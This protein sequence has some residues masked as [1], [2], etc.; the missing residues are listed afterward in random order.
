MQYYPTPPRPEQVQGMYP[1]PAPLQ[2]NLPPRMQWAP[3]MAAPWG[4]DFTYHG[5]A[6]AAGGP[7][8][9]P[10]DQ[11][12]PHNIR[13]ILGAQQGSLASGIAK[14]PTNTSAFQ[15][16]MP[17]GHGEILRSPTTP[18]QPGKSVEVAAGHFQQGEMQP[19]FYIP[20]GTTVA[21]RQY[22]ESRGGLYCQRDH[23]LSAA[24]PSLAH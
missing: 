20:A 3:N 19:T 21:G 7:P 8:G 12:T 11:S 23:C 10:T 18:T 9:T 2:T 13:D 24:K 4:Y 14:S 15:Y 16:P 17:A 5:A 22:G 6:Y 1:Y